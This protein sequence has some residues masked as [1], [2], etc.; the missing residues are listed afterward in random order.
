MPAQFIVGDQVLAAA[1]DQHNIAVFRVGDCFI[2]IFE[3]STAANFSD[4]FTCLRAAG[5]NTCLYDESTSLDA[6][7]IVSIVYW[8]L[9]TLGP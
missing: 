8:A 9:G 2:L 7:I 1:T 5:Q 3:A 4:P 6:L